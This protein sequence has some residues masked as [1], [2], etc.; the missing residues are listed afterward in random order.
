MGRHPLPDDGGLIWLAVPSQGDAGAATIRT[1]LLRTGGHA[2]LVR[3]P[4]PLRAAVDVFQPLAAPLMR[5]TAG[6]K[7]SFDPAGVLE[8]GRMYAGI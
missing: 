8:P 2:T 5:L 7:T 3:A 1:A 6:V 4:D